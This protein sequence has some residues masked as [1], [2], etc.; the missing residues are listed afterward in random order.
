[1]IAGYF[2]EAIRGGLEAIPQ[3]QWDA[4]HALGMRETQIL[5]KVVIPQTLLNSWPS[6]VNYL[7]I[8]LYGTAL[9]STLDLHEITDVAAQVNTA[10]YRPYDVYLYALLLYYA[11]SSLLRL[12]AGRLR[13]VIDPGRRAL[14]GRK[15]AS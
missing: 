6:L 7:M 8:V 12:L 1:M 13:R 14:K 9:L 5:W 2:A 15:W 11:I 3:G 4:C 10:T